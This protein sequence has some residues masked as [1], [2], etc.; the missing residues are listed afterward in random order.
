MPGKDLAVVDALSKSPVPG[1]GEPDSSSVIEAYVQSVASVWPLSD[2]HLDGIRNESKTDPILKEALHFTA[3]DWSTYPK[4]YAKDLF[5]LFAIKNEL[6]IY[7][8]FLI[9]GIKIVMP[10]SLSTAKLEKNPPWSS[11][12][13]EIQRKGKIFSMVARHKQRER[14]KSSVCWPGI[15]NDIRNVVTLCQ[16]CEERRPT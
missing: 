13:D 9:R 5:S 1:L 3:M 14:A 4:N 12:H 6:S 15:S 10:S 16:H 2:Q 8:G 7:Q 11:G